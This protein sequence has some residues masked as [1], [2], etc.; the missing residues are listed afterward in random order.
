MFPEY[1]IMA[2]AMSRYPLQTVTLPIL[3]PA[4]GEGD[5]LGWWHFYP[6]KGGEEVIGVRAVNPEYIKAKWRSILPAADR[7][8]FESL[9]ELPRAYA[10]EDRKEILRVSKRTQGFI[11]EI[12]GTRLE[13]NWAD[14]NV[15]VGARG[16]YASLMTTALQSV[17]LG[18]WFTAKKRLFSPAIFCPDWR[19]AA[20]AILFTDG[21]RICPKCKL[22]FIPEKETQEYCTPAH[23]V[24]F[25]TARSR[26]KKKRLDKAKDK[27]GWPGNGI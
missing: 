21:L 22:P 5:P 4:S 10:T 16:Q 26:A 23:G 2:I 24:A 11:P 17:R 8:L 12:P 3:I 6:E 7:E 14:E 25:R 13:F 20:F 18:L 1:V 19:S 27:K 15:I 9:S